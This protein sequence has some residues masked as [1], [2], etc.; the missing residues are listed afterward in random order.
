MH[1]VNK[2]LLFFII[3]YDFCFYIEFYMEFLL[4]T[5]AFV[6]FL[7]TLRIMC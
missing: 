3:L 4:L 5:Y 2:L 1:F 7:F 6:A